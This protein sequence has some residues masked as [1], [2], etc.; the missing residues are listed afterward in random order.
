MSTPREEQHALIDSLPEEAAASLL[1]ALRVQRNRSA[2]A[3]SSVS[4]QASGAWPPP[5]FGSVEGSR[6]DL[7][8]HLDDILRAE[9]VR[10][11]A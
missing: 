1:A 5:W 7:S 4:E 3:P 6:P 8:E 11:P 10:R 9:F 2:H